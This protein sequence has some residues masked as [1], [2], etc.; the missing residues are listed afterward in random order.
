MSEQPKVTRRHVLLGG[1]A[2]AAMAL[3]PS[4]FDDTPTAYAMPSSRRKYH[5]SINPASNAHRY[6]WLETPSSTSS[7]VP[8]AILIHGGAWESEGGPASMRF[9]SEFLCQYGVACWNIEYRALGSGGGWPTTYAD[10]CDAIDHLIA[11]KLSVAPKLDLDRVYIVGHSAG[12]QLGALAMGQS[13]RKIDAMG[14]LMNTPLLRLTTE[15]LQLADLRGD[16]SL[17][18][19]NKDTVQHEL[20]GT[21]NS[22]GRA[23]VAPEGP[24]IPIRGFVSLN[25][26][27]DVVD[28]AKRSKFSNI[29]VF[30]GGT[31]AEVPGNY[32]AANPIRHIPANKKM[33]LV[34]GT[35]DYV[36]PQGQVM[37]YGAAASRY[38]NTV[39][40]LTLQGAKH[41]DVLLPWRNPEAYQAV[42]K[43]LAH[44]MGAKSTPKKS[45]RLFD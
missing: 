17:K 14:L 2:V 6:G 40:Y 24:R 36:I 19:G 20:V 11:L 3:A 28:S 32:A 45:R 27:L 34:Q 4:V 31:P 37:R 15:S 23:T 38:G 13:P 18:R 30:L 35:R 26:V 25:G 10:V 7:A 1:V 39:T 5:Y 44:F 33:L 9:L 21:G 42:T 43:A 29:R 16:I 41:N 8:V 12:A 22:A